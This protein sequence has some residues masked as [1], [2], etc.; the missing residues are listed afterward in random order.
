L[1]ILPAIP[2]AAVL[3]ADLLIAAAAGAVKRGVQWTLAAIAVLAVALGVLIALFFTSGHYQLRSAWILA[4]ILG[5][6]GVATIIP[7]ARSRVPAATF[8]LATGFVLFNYVFV[9]GALPDVERLKPV[10]VLARVI[11]AR[12][13]ASA[14]LAALSI[15]LPSLVY[16][17]ARP[18]TRL[19]SVEEA[20]RFVSDSKEAWMIAGEP[21][22]EALH[23]QAPGACIAARTPLFLAKG[24]DIVRG[25]APPD[26]LLITNQCR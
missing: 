13:T 6:T 5:L 18:V 26:V 8:A 11:E 7:L 3:V 25:Q 21:D 20:A 9:I 19:W 15:D 24:S 4:V 10:P 16:Y 12:A 1:Y 23:R 2:A 14:P 22:W 17:A